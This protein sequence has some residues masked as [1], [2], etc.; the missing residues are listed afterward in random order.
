MSKIGLI[1]EKK[2]YKKGI[3]IIVKNKIKQHLGMAQTNENMFISGSFC[4]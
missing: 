3:N 4:T 1:K 2:N